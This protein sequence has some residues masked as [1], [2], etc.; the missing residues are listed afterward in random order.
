M[1]WIPLTACLLGGCSLVLDF[2]DSAI[3]IDATPDAAFSEAECTFGEPNDS[4]AAASV[5]AVTDVGPAAICADGFDDHD[6]Y[7]VTI[8]A[9]SAVTLTVSFISSATGDL[10]LRLYD[11]TGATVLAR[12][13]GFMNQETIT[14]PG[15]SPACTALAA[16]DYIFEVFPA[17]LGA[18][19]RYD[20]ALTVTP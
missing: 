15:A 16:D 18:K 4:A 20:I 6:F 3:P 19:N 17:V 2:S 13:S 8:P 10:D 5:F 11:K 9:N 1:R 14:C 7:K 12:S